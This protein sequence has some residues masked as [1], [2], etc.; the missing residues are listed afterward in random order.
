M[1]SVLVSLLNILNALLLGML[2]AQVLKLLPHGI[3]KTTLD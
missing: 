2:L 1:V 3:V